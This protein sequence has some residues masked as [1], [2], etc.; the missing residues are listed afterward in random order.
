MFTVTERR[1]LRYTRKRA[2]CV[3]GPPR[4]PQALPSVSPRDTHVP[5]R[6]QGRGCDPSSSHSV[7]DLAF[8]HYSSPRPRTG[9]TGVAE[10]PA[11]VER[12]RQE[13]GLTCGREHL[14]QPKLGSSRT[15]SASGNGSSHEVGPGQGQGLSPVLEMSRARSQSSG[16]GDLLRPAS[17]LHGCSRAPAPG[18]VEARLSEEPC[19][20]WT[21]A[22]SRLRPEQV[23]PGG[24]MPLRADP[25]VTVGHVGPLWG[26]SGSVLQS[27]FSSSPH[28]LAGSAALLWD[29][30]CL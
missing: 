15:G 26:R 18:P 30:I 17:T 13:Q 12:H 2:S 10:A 19:S 22:H 29:G 28:P 23:R 4:P 7:R 27:L 8:Q 14:A 1:N 3:S 25:Q 11:Q 20:G 5:L 16:A 24:C 9:G 6:A 21:W